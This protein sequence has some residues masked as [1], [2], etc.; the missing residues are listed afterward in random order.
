[1]RKMCFPYYT[2][3]SGSTQSRVC[4]ERTLLSIHENDYNIYLFIYPYYITCKINNILIKTLN[5]C[6]PNSNI[7]EKS[8]YFWK[9]GSY[10]TSHWDLH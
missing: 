9:N 4:V 10:L 1:M 2:Y 7:F 5:A 3:F 6:K 8:I